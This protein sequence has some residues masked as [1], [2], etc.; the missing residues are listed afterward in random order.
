MNPIG[1]LYLV[2]ALVDY[3]VK[4]VASFKETEQGRAE[5]LDVEARYAQAIGDDMAAQDARQEAS[6]V[7]RDSRPAAAVSK[8]TPERINLNDQ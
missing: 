6:V 8:G 7:R 5:W 4:A 1:V 3:A 2:V